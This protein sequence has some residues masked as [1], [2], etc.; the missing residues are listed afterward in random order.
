MSAVRKNKERDNS[1]TTYDLVMKMNQDEDEKRAGNQ[2]VD[3][4]ENIMD[5]R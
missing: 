3:Q 1:S 5:A 4:M 2:Q